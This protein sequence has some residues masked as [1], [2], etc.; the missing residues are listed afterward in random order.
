MIVS[1]SIGGAWSSHMGRP[2]KSSVACLRKFVLWMCFWGRE[3]SSTLMLLF[4]FWILGCFAW[5]SKHFGCQWWPF[6][7]FFW[8][9]RLRGTE[10]L[11]KETQAFIAWSTSTRGVYQLWLCC[12]SKLLYSGL[13]KA[14]S[15]L[16]SKEEH[17]LKS[18]LV[19]IILPSVNKSHHAGWE[20]GQRTAIG[21]CWSDVSSRSH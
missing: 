20:G 8:G 21:D 17:L 19:G 16:K 3:Q 9:I 1:L 14:H 15:T 2:G 4:W 18:C 11:S 6:L 5:S 12:Q 13:K 7:G 10:W